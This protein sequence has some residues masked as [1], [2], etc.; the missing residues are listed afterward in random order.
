[1]YS[2]DYVAAAQQ[3]NAAIRVAKSAND[4]AQFAESLTNL[5]NRSLRFPLHGSLQ[6]IGILAGAQRDFCAFFAEL[7]AFEEIAYQLTETIADELHFDHMV[8]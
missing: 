5:G 4:V 3:L 6:G 7:E 8:N 1:M 2:G